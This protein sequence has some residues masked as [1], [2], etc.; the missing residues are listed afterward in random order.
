MGTFG[1]RNGPGAP[2]V[3]ATALLSRISVLQDAEDQDE[4]VRLCE[5]KRVNEELLV[6]AALSIR[7]RQS[8]RF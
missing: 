3:P 1:G 7:I 6:V 5:T 4:V 8:T 2:S